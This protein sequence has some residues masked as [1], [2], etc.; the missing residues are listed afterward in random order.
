MRHSSRPCVIKLA[1]PLPSLPDFVCHI[2]TTLLFPSLAGEYS[3][4]LAVQCYSRAFH[5]NLLHL[6]PRIRHPSEPDLALS[7]GWP[8]CTSTLT[9]SCL[10]SC[11][12]VPPC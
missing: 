2:L 1:E 12:A 5:F 3:R 9:Y 7:L 6:R 8:S 11:S 4:F 10:R